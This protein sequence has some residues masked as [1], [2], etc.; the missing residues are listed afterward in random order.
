MS[1]A[2]LHH[3]CP[4]L[5]KHRPSNLFL[6]KFVFGPQQ[7]AENH[8]PQHR[9][10]SRG[11]TRRSDDARQAAAEPVY[12]ALLVRL[13]ARV[14]PLDTLSMAGLRHTYFAQQVKQTSEWIA[15][16]KYVRRLKPPN[17]SPTA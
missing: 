4:L 2:F 17:G 14:D 12:K 1:A 3:Q 10:D 8:N 7:A 16:A 11:Q 13:V 6:I 15:D 5:A 9:R